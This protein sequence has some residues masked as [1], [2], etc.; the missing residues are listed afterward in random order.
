M[1]MRVFELAKELNIPTKELIKKIK[2]MDIAITGNFSALSDEQITLIKKDL[3][4]PAT[5]IEEAEVSSQAGVKKVRRRIISAKKATEGKKIKASLKIEDKPLEEDVETRRKKGEDEPE[6]M[7]EE[8]APKRVVRRKADAK[9]KPEPE[10]VQ[11]VEEDVAEAEE[12]EVEEKPKARVIK[13]KVKAEKDDE[14]EEADKK[15][16]EP[17][18][19]KGKLPVEG[20]AHPEFADEVEEEAAEEVV[21]V[22]EEKDAPKRTTKAKDVMDNIRA[23]AKKKQEPTVNQKP[24]KEK[25]VVKPVVRVEEPVSEDPIK[26]TVNQKQKTA[27]AE[28]S[29]V[30]DAANKKSDDK[31]EDKKEGK[32][33]KKDKKQEKAIEKEKPIDEFD[34]KQIK[35]LQKKDKV[36]ISKKTFKEELEVVAVDEDEA[37]GFIDDPQPE[38][39]PKPH[40]RRKASKA[41]KRKEKAKKQAEIKKQKHVFNPRQ[42]ELVVGEFVTIGDLAGIIGVKVP[43]IIKSLMSLG[44]MATITQSIDGETAALVASEH[45]IEL[46]VQFESIEDTI[47]TSEDEEGALE[48]RPPVVTI[49]GHVD[50]GKTSLL[51]KIRKSNVTDDEAG[52]ITQHIGAYHVKTPEGRITFLD[53]PGHEAFT[54]MRARGADVTDIVILVVAADDGPRPQTVEAIHHAKAAEVAII[55]AINKCDKPDA[56]PDKTIQQLMEHELVPEE[57]GGDIPMIKVS[58]KKGEGISKLME[59]VHL[60]AE[61]MELKANPSRMAIGTVIESK[62][63]KGRGNAATILIQNGTLRVGDSYVVGTEYGRVRAMWNDRG[64]K[65]SEATP[66]IPVEIVGLN[67]VPKAGDPFNVGQ[68]EK[69]VRQ[70]AVLRTEKEKERRQAQQQKRTLENLFDSMDKEEKSILNLIIKTDV[71]GSLDALSDSLLRL[72]NEQVAINII[73]GA[74]G[75]ITQHDVLLATTSKAFIIGFN[76]R[77][78]PTAKNLAHEEGIE[79]R[80]Y[81]VIYEVIEDVKHALEG[82]LKPIIRE[83]IQGKAEVLEVFNI[84]KI[85]I[86]AGSKVVEGKFIRDSSVRVIRDNVIIHDGKMSSLQRFKDAAKEVQTGFECGIGLDAYKDLKVGDEL[87]SYI[88]LETAAKL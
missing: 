41:A 39:T 69:Q 15:K 10:E 52:G 9:P 3:L 12:V 58:A 11:A 72:G 33:R 87:E 84:P 86:I 78:D 42:K 74:V 32:V 19:P 49:M 65:I 38:R 27:D 81:S 50:H 64:K 75:A 14:P 6:E 8:K 71:N 60:Q 26:V 51:D 30:K 1:S 83:E 68:D 53:T 23:S 20:D 25:E 55:V 35:S 21:E 85:G 62:V 2:A 40:M 82:M 77:P 66:A 73:H 45:G 48:F 54:A 34:K 80:L 47:D 61:I 18:K 70:I 28:E 7:A 63:D 67:G 29:K 44:I 16:K 31:S 56:N 22:A 57:F 5:R 4:E 17:A 59:M 37:V 24:A 79:I 36:K 43:D 76:T 46:K 13:A 88:R